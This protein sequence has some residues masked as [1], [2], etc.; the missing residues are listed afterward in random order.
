MLFKARENGCVHVSLILYTKTHILNFTNIINKI[1][2]VV[3]KSLSLSLM[4]YQVKV[5]L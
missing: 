1:K 5:L 3:L 2:N 4:Y